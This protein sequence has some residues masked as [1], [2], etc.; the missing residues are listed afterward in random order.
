MAQ[1]ATNEGTRQQNG[2]TGQSRGQ[3]KPHSSDADINA[4]MQKFARALSAG[5]GKTIAT[6]WSV[7]ALVLSDQG[8]IAVSSRDEVEKFFSG[9]KEQY[10]ARGINQAAPE[11]QST[12]WLTGRIAMARVRWPYIDSKG[13]EMGEESSTYTFRRDD[14]G[15]LKMSAI[16]MHGEKKKG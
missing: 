7:P 6:M 1:H 4:F 10:A 15:E 16:V 12:D 13:H 2:L 14:G 9:A 3:P 11:I 8:S 5:D